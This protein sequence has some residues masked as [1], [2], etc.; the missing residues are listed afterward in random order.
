MLTKC[1]ECGGDVSDKAKVCPHCGAPTGNI[2]NPLARISKCL[3]SRFERWSAKRSKVTIKEGH[4]RREKEEALNYAVSFWYDSI[5]Y[6]GK[7]AALDYADIRKKL[8]SASSVNMIMTALSPFESPQ[9]G[10]VVNLPWLREWVR[11]RRGYLVEVLFVA[12]AFEDKELCDELI[13]PGYVLSAEN[14]SRAFRLYCKPGYTKVEQTFLDRYVPM[15]ENALKEYAKAIKWLPLIESQDFNTINF[16]RN[17][18]V[19]VKIGDEG[20]SYYRHTDFSHWYTYEY[21]SPLSKALDEDNIERLQFLL[22]WGANPNQ[23]LYWSCGRRDGS[24]PIKASPLLYKIKSVEAYKLMKAGGM[25]DYPIPNDDKPNECCN[26]VE[27]LWCGDAITGKRLALLNYLYEIG[28]DKPIVARL[29][30]VKKALDN[31]NYKNNSAIVHEWVRRN[32]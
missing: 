18:G 14:A 21:E 8:I 30:A 15:N 32:S 9:E 2:S 31:G 11:V 19:D 25:P 22:N 3:K 5:P 24:K 17:I 26:L 1:N 7:Y 6:S 13:P 20:L 12:H 27:H 23:Y 16:F 29:L 10:Y 28:Y 4:C